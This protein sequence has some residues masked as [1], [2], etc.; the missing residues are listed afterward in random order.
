MRW[1]GHEMKIAHYR[2]LVRRPTGKRPLVR[3]G[4]KWDNVKSLLKTGEKL[5]TGQTWLR[6]G[7]T[8]G[9]PKYSNEITGPIRSGEVLDYTCRVPR[10]LLH[11]HTSSYVKKQHVRKRMHRITTIRLTE[12]KVL[13][14]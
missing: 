4:R 13:W 14:A 6:T 3:S 2:L 8:E 10:I 11:G 12:K 9:H 5:W 1:P 7:N